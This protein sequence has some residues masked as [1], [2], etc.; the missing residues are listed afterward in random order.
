MHFPSAPYS[1]QRHPPGFLTP[2]RPFTPAT[3]VGP[4][5][6]LLPP[7]QL[8][9]VG[10]PWAR[11]QSCMPIASLWTHPLNDFSL[12]MDL[13]ATYSSDSQM[14]ISSAEPSLGSIF[15]M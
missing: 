10:C 3:S 12:F 5:L 15:E 14:C 13:C 9:N 11:V 7:V 8:L 4:N 6:Q 2:G 1:H